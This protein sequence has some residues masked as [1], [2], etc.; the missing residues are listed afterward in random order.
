MPIDNPVVRQST[1]LGS[2]AK[3]LHG[4]AQQ[5]SFSTGTPP[6]PPRYVLQHGKP[7]SVKKHLPSYFNPHLTQ[8]N[9]SIH[10]CNKQ[11]FMVPKQL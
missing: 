7:T 3:H 9:Y 5:Q 10:R 11:S 2:S 8:S 6:L 4:T 1:A